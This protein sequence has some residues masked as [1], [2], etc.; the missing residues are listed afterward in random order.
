M[1]MDVVVGLPAG[2][3]GLGHR[4]ILHLRQ[5][6]ACTR[7]AGFHLGANFGRALAGL[8]GGRT[9]A[10]ERAVIAFFGVR[11][12]GSLYYVAYAVSEGSFPGEDGLWALVGLAV[13]GSIL[14]HGVSATPVMTWLD[15]R[16]VVA[17]R[18]RHGDPDAAPVT[19]V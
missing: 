1:L 6:V 19:P 18:D 14:L 2:R 4:S 9:G 13:V 12:V 5:A 7:E 17:A 3:L 15:R 11:G 8:A 16:R 10:R